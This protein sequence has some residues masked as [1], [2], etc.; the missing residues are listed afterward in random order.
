MMSNFVERLD[1]LLKEQELNQKTFA[2]K[3]GISEGSISFYLQDKHIPTVAH[4]VK[5]AD[6]FQ[7]STDFLLGREEENRKLTFKPCP[8][9]CE[10]IVN[11]KNEFGGV[12][13]RFVKKAK[14]ARSSYFNWA[15]S[16][17][18]PSLDN[19]ITL[20]DHLDRRVD[21]I[22]GRES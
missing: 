11:L 10:Q 13:D 17:Y 7:C 8:P 4:L 5:I 18:V 2:E 15:S 21:Y 19:I 1:Y 22:L 14:I 6:Y 12:V 20:A 16:K 3:V 9:F